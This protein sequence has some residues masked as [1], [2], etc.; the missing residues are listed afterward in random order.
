MILELAV[1]NVRAG[2]A[3]AFEAAFDEAK[4]II[5]AS[6]GFHR[7]ELRRCLETADRYVL[8]VEW[9]RLEDHTAGFRGSDGY[10]RWRVMLHH[11]YDPFPVVEHYEPLVEVPAPT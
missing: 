10:Q 2:E 8:L 7:L 11:F 6:P 4:A 3:S 9:E 1:L 5:S